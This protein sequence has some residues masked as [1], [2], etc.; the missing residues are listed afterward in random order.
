MNKVSQDDIKNMNELYIKLG[1]YAAVARETGF[2][3]ST[4]K[5]Y[6][7]PHYVSDE[8]SKQNRKVF[9]LE[10]IPDDVDPKS[11]CIDNWGD[12]C[13]LTYEEK[14]GM[15]ELWEEMSL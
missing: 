10:S 9:D 13:E 15:I 1:T 4:V 5:K 11:F 2:S 14:M 8:V 12:L 6:I 3:A 7:V